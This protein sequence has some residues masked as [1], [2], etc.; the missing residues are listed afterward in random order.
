VGGQCLDDGLVYPDSS[1]VLV[2]VQKLHDTKM[3]I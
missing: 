3:L 2:F 1:E